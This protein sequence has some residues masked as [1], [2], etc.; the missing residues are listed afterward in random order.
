MTHTLHREGSLE[1]LGQDFVVIGMP[2]K[3]VTT[4]GSGPKLKRFLELAQKYR[5]VNIGDSKTGNR[6]TLGGAANV[7]RAVK[8]G[9][10]C[11]AVY[12][13]PQAVISL[14]RD[15]QAEDTGMSFTVSGLLDAVDHCC[16]E[17]G[18]KRHTVNMSLGVYGRTDKLPPAEVREISTMCGHGM[19]T[20]A[21]ILS[22]VEKI[23]QGVLT[24]EKAAE[25]LAE[26]CLCG[27]F[28]PRRAARLLRAMAEK[29]GGA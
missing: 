11:H 6:Y 29:G 24:P 20:A 14:L 10:V 5:P 8:D 3:G 7:V 12:D 28:N 25:K 2:C 26:P 18:L 17:A 23:K 21:L 16:R 1:E 22:L 19:V 27:I 4:D 9:S 15:L 13:N